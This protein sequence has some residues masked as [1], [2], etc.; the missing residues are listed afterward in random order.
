MNWYKKN[1]IKYSV[2]IKDHFFVLSII[3]L[4]LINCRLLC[5]AL[6]WLEDPFL[7]TEKI[8]AGVVFVIIIILMIIVIW[9]AFEWVT[10]MLAIIL[11]IGTAEAAV[12][13]DFACLLEFH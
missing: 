1:L 9:I 11:L 13:K 8:A 12:L 5:C 7:V 4:T 2:E 10:A 6:Y 3:F